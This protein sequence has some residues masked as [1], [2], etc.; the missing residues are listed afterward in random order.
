[1]LVW[2]LSISQ[3]APKWRLSIQSLQFVT[4]A[5]IDQRFI[6]DLTLYFR[7]HEMFWPIKCSLESKAPAPYTINTRWSA[8]WDQSVTCS[9][10][11][12]FLYGEWHVVQYIGD[13]ERFRQCKYALHWGKISLV[14]RCHAGTCQAEWPRRSLSFFTHKVY[15]PRAHSLLQSR[16]TTARSGSH[17]LV[18][19]D[20]KTY[21]TH[22]NSTQ[23]AIF[24][25]NMDEIVAV[26]Q[27]QM[28]LYW[29]QWL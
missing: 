2:R 17:V 1:M 23:N 13:R 4:S 25:S 19:T 7:S 8:G 5:K 3:C 9:Q 24:Y 10:D 22:L 21:R 20:H 12:Y 28:W 11:L 27:C 29:A 26:I 16:D 18:G 6:F 15:T 14:S